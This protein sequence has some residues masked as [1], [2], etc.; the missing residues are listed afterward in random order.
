MQLPKDQYPSTATTGEIADWHE[1][2]RQANRFSFKQRIKVRQAKWRGR[3]RGWQ[4]IRKAEQRKPPWFTIAPEVNPDNVRINQ[5]E[6]GRLACVQCGSVGA[7]HRSALCPRCLTTAAEGPSVLCATCEQNIENPRPGDQFCK[8]CLKSPE[9]DLTTLTASHKRYVARQCM[10]HGK[11]PRE[12]KL[13]VEPTATDLDKERQRQLQRR[14]DRGKPATHNSTLGAQCRICR[15]SPVANAE[16]VCSD[17]AGGVQKVVGFQDGQRIIEG[18]D[19]WP[20]G[21]EVNIENEAD[22][23]DDPADAMAWTPAQQ[24]SGP[25]DWNQFA[26]AYADDPAELVADES[27]VDTPSVSILPCPACDAALLR[28]STVKPGEACR[29]GKWRHMVTR[30]STRQVELIKEKL[31]ANR[32][33]R[34]TAIPRG[35]TSPMLVAETCSETEREHWSWFWANTR[36]YSEKMPKG[37]ER[38]AALLEHGNPVRHVTQHESLY[39]E[40]KLLMEELANIDHKLPSPRHSRANGRAKRREAILG[41]Y[42]RH[43]VRGWHPPTALA[44][45]ERFDCD[46]DHVYDVL[47]PLNLMYKKSERYAEPPCGG[48]LAQPAPNIEELTIG[49]W[50]RHILDGETAPSAVEIARRYDLCERR[51]YQALEPLE[52]KRLDVSKWVVSMQMSCRLKTPKM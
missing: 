10:R 24:S 19:K 41:A 15:Q 17:C 33:A 39:R 2:I 9:F 13:N 8:A 12:L 34:E 48:T 26:D 5:D 51:V 29:P 6:P 37:A 22:I 46:L 45:A 25:S 36:R 35:V 43:I 18:V 1:R 4:I 30:E 21:Y 44:L 11:T 28:H 42:L 40:H 16:D 38:D 47:K 20:T 32:I 3:V 31:R 27:V 52:S 23:A 49:V 7:T 14:R 50:I